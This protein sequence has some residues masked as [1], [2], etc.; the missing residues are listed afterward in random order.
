MV[1]APL[2]VMLGSGVT[3]EGGLGEGVTSPPMGDASAIAVSASPPVVGRGGGSAPE[4]LQAISP[5]SRARVV[6]SR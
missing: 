6:R 5:S 4:T 3:V 2:T 1:V